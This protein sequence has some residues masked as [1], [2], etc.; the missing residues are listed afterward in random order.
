[1]R[2]LTAGGTFP[3]CTQHT[4]VAMVQGRLAPFTTLRLS[5]SAVRTQPSTV[6]RFDALQLRAAATSFG[7]GTTSE[8]SDLRLVLLRRPVITVWLRMQEIS[9]HRMKGRIPLGCRTSG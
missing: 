7:S 3:L 2:Y 9:C 5:A 8:V 1:M 6:R 4:T